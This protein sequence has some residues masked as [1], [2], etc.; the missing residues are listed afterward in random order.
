MRWILPFLL[1]IGL[2]TANELAKERIWTGTNGKTFRG[3]YLRTLPEGDKVEIVSTQGRLY[4]IAI[5]NLSGPDQKLLADP[6]EDPGP[7]RPATPPAGDPSLFREMPPLN[8]ELISKAPNK[9]DGFKW[10]NSVLQAIGSFLYWWDLSE[11]VAIPR[12]GDAEKKCDWAADKLKRKISPRN[13]KLAGSEQLMEGLAGYFE[14]ELAEVATYAFH[15]VVNPTQERIAAHTEAGDACFIKISNDG[16]GIWFA[17]I[18]VQG[19]VVR[20]AYNGEILMLKRSEGEESNR[21]LSTQGERFKI[22]TAGLD[23][24]LLWNPYKDYWEASETERG[25]KREAFKYA[26]LEI[27]NKDDVPSHW[28]G[29]ELIFR[30]Y[31]SDPMVVCRPYP[32]ADPEKTGPPPTDPAFGPQPDKEK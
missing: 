4:V 17:V 8:R 25:Q 1:C 18:D 2:A 6:G 16:W 22:P 31:P 9:E 10:D 30:L 32:F 26:V 23:E 24:P 11:V 7:P 14:S 20:V 12:R 19:D 21:Y 13:T 15:L 5:A 3:L 28:S 29:D 27:M